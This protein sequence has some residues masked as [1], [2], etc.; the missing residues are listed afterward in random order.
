MP[1]FISHL[2]Q[3]YFESFKASQHGVFTTV[4]LSISLFHSVSLPFPF[5][6]FISTLLKSLLLLLL[7]FFSF[8]CSSPISFSPSIQTILLH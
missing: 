7:L 2:S 3:L 8:V 6:N 5:N 1:F 4:P